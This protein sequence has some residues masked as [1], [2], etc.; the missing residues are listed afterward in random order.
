MGVP[1]TEKH[2]GD[3]QYATRDAVWDWEW[4]RLVGFNA[5]RCGWCLVMGWPRCIILVD[6]RIQRR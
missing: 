5:F 1:A 6:Y 4:E 3:V 2:V